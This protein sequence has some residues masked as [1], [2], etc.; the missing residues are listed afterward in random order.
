MT[1][2]SALF[3]ELLLAAASS[4][5][6]LSGKIANRPPDFASVEKP[7]KD[8]CNTYCALLFAGAGKQIKYNG[9]S[10]CSI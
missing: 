8:A 10:R 5:A 7:G 6:G 3:L 1:N 4:G 9:T 2:E